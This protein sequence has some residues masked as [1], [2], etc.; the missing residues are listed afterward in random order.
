MARPH[1]SEEIQYYE[2]QFSDYSNVHMTYSGSVQEWIV[3]ATEVI[4]HDCTTGIEAFI[5]GKPVFSFCPIFDPNLI[6]EMP[7][8]ISDVRKNGTAHF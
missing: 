6:Q 3:N 8:S 7:K 4:H 2:K 1:P 5:C